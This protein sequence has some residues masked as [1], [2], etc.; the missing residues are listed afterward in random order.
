MV[1]TNPGGQHFDEENELWRSACL[2]RFAGRQGPELY[3][4]VI[5]TSPWHASML[6]GR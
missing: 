1:D 4:R 3:D 2:M 6:T 5:L